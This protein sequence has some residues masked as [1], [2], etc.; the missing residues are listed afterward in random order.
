MDP[1]LHAKLDD[2]VR[3]LLFHGGTTAAAAAAASEIGSEEGLE[4]FNARKSTS[5]RIASGALARTAIRIATPAARSSV[6][7]S[8]VQSSRMDYATPAPTI[9]NGIRALEF[10]PNIHTIVLL[11]PPRVPNSIQIP[12]EFIHLSHVDE[13]FVNDFQQVLNASVDRIDLYEKMDWGMDVLCV[14]YGAHIFLQKSQL[15][16]VR[17]LRRSKQA[18]P[19]NRHS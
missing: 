17:S 4:I 1:T 19:L 6:S 10:I 16:S 8:R 3:Y 18:H 5:P 15:F 9:T 13:K 2:I 12:L 11:P 7:R 14:D